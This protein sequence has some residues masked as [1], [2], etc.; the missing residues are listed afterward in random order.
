MSIVPLV[1][2]ATPCYNASRTLARA[3]ASLIAQTYER[4]ECLVVDDGSTDDPAAVVRRVD[5]PRIRFISLGRNRGRGAA[6]Q[7]A[8]DQ[9][10]GDLLGMLDADDWYYPD[11]LARQVEAFRDRPGLTVVGTG[12]AILDRSGGLAG[13]R[14]CDPIS[15]AVAGLERPRIA[16]APALIRMDAARAA[17]Y[18]ASLNHAEDVDFLIRVLHRRRYAVVPA[19]LY[20]YSEHESVGLE[21]ILAGLR[22]LR[23]VFRKH[24]STAPAAT[25]IDEAKLALKIPAYRLGFALGL[26][27][28]MIRSRSALPGAATLDEFGRARTAVDLAQASLGTTPSDRTSR[29]LDVSGARGGG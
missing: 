13:V 28:A 3:L 1:S 11:K 23:R 26:G 5:D 19:P 4:W 7:V 12:M 15:D 29:R 9:A 22:S 14:C 16:H 10:R 8:L 24:R 6:R 27:E 21:K 17:G 2:I 25:R 20:A 18:D